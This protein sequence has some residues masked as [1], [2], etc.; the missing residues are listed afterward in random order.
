MQLCMYAKAIRILAKGYLPI[1]LISPTK[2]QEIL[3]AAQTAIQKTNLDY[4]LVIKSLH[5]NYYMKLVT[6]G[7]DND[8]N[9]TIQFPVFIQPYTQQLLILYQIERVPVPILDQ[10]KQADSYTHLQI[11]RPYITLN[12]ETYISIRQQKLQTCN[13][14]GYEFYCKELFMVKH[15]TKYSCA[16]V[17]YFNI[18]PDI[19]NNNCKFTYYYDKTDITPQ[20]L[21]EETKLF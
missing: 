14:I 4:D 8:Q 15:K 12:S 18:G 16:S 5:L 1:S 7:I 9:L 13:K 2:L 10:N 6:F 3:N 21:M 11:D 19:I 20:F 17:I